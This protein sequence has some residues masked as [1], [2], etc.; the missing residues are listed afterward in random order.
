MEKSRI[1]YLVFDTF[2]TVV[3]WRGT[4]QREGLRLTETYGL[5]VDWNDLAIRWRKEGYFKVTF[6]IAAGKRPWIS[7]DEIFTEFLLDNKDGL[8]LTPVPDQAL[9]EFSLVWHR[10]APWE[11]A[12]EGLTRLKNKYAIGPFSN[13]DFKLMLD[14]AKSGGLP[15]DF[16]TSGDLFRKFKPDPTIY[17]DEVALL[18]VEPCEVAMVSAHPFDLDGAKKIG[19][20]TLYVPRPEEYGRDSGYVE[21]EGETAY[22]EKLSNFLALADFMGV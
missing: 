19:C 17:Q 3:D 20:M 5:R 2:G 9:K 1:K 8:G 12:I 14:I 16:I 11:D 4:I 13:G 10:L 6:D 18:G 21:P 22:D 7:A 15:W